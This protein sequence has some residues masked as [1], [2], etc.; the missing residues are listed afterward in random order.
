MRCLGKLCQ[1]IP[2]LFGR[3]LD[4]LFALSKEQ[5]LAEGQPYLDALKTHFGIELAA[6]YEA[7]RPLPR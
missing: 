7:L 3:L 6:P 4:M 1:S 5:G 2:C